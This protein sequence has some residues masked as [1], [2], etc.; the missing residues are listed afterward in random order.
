MVPKNSEKVSDL[1]QSA[2]RTRELRDRHE[3]KDMRSDQSEDQAQQTHPQ[4]RCSKA[5]CFA[6]TPTERAES[7]AVCSTTRHSNDWLAAGG[8]RGGATIGDDDSKEDPL[9]G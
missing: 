5:R 4:G 3:S 9:K 8:L 6:P 7:V 2:V 1:D